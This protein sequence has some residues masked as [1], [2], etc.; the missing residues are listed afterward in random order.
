MEA[1]HDG[2]SMM[3]I[4]SVLKRIHATEMFDLGKK[5]SQLVILETSQ[6]RVA[7]VLRYADCIDVTPTR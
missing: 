5:R 4:Y 1:S 7:A 2:G 3:R 6:N